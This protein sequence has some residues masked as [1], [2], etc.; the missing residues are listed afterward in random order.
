MKIANKFLPAGIV[1]KVYSR[2][3][4]LWLEQETSNC[5]QYKKTVQ[6]QA[7]SVEDMSLPLQENWSKVRPVILIP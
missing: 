6:S 7:L 2:F 1:L 5:K 3:P 4:E